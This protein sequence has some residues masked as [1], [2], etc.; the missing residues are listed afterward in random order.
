MTAFAAVIG[1]AT[2]EPA[3]LEAARAVG[4]GLAENS[5]V[6]L[7]GG[8]GGVMDA[9]CEGAALA[10]GTSIGFLPGDDRSAAGPSVSM[11]LATGL[12]EGR[13]ILVVT[14]A[15]VVV[16][17]GGSWGTLSEIAL[18]RRV[19]KPVVSLLGWRLQPPEVDNELLHA[20][21]PEEAVKYALL[22]TARRQGHDKT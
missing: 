21:T 11:P 9:A 20:S 8:L 4:R 10:G 5:F 6:V 14:A 13:N 18:A 19:G 7:T 3:W 16:S 2:A 1:P 17:I 22:S 15:D 12:G